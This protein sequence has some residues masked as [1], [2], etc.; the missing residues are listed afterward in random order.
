MQKM[1]KT[2]ERIARRAHA[3]QVDKAGVPYAHHPAWVAA[4]VE[5][6][7]AKAAAWLHDVLEDTSL[8]ADDLR[9]AGIP[10]EVVHTVEVL[11]HAEGESYQDYLER[12]A[13]HPLAARVKLAD[14]AH[15]SDL[16]RIPQPTEQDYARIEK[17]R[18]ARI[19]L[20][21]AVGDR[22]GK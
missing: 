1:V 3:G 10:E 8:T 20:E 13:R 12:V 16:S 14:L 19:F 21:E 2:A 9:R 22:K 17:Y 15:N 4:R 5:G 11:T 7:D 6:D 18:R